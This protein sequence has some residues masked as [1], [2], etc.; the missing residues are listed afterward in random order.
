VLPGTV[1]AGKERDKDVTMQKPIS[2]YKIMLAIFA[3][4]VGLAAFATPIVL[5]SPHYN[6]A[7]KATQTQPF[8][9]R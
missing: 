4:A 1:S 8:V 7:S 3:L 5:S 6:G 2:I 9:P